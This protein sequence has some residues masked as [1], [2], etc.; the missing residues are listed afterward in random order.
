MD[1]RPA[2]TLNGISLCSGV[3][4]L[5]LGL[6]LALG[7]RYRC[8]VYV[9]REAY[10]AAALVARVEDEALD[11]APIWDDLTS[12][13]GKPWRGVVDIVSAGFPCQPWSVAG[14]RNRTDDPRWLWPQILRIVKEVQPPFVFLE[15]VSGLLGGGIQ[16]VLE[17]LAA[18][19]YDAEWG[20]FSAGA[21]GA[22]HQRKRLFIL[23]YAERE[24]LEGTEPH[25]FWDGLSER[26]GDEGGEMANAEGGRHE[27]R[28]VI[29]RE[30]LADGGHNASR[31]REDL[32]VW[33]PAPQDNERWGRLLGQFPELS[34]TLESDVRGMADGVP[35]WVDRIRAL[36]NAVVPLA[37]ATAFVHLGKRARRNP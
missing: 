13:D 16:I 22:P 25:R 29:G 5:E 19:G 34:P 33:P 17:D 9:E 21:V 6:K 4:G 7:D 35:D 31:C 20:M 24:P 26:I 32:G 23:A 8:V 2:G 1:L 37:A 3:A 15:N 30:A 14:K 11:S 36:G 28:A 12:F 10:A 27:A 18:M